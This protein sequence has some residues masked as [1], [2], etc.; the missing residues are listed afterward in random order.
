[1]SGASLNWFYVVGT[2]RFGMNDQRN[3]QVFNSFI[4]FAFA[5][6]VSGL[7]FSPSSEAHVRST[8]AWFKCPG[9]GS[10]LGILS[11]TLP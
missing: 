3:A 9:D 8:S 1:M 11:G 4:N 7:S 2:V 6:H 10:A 5:L